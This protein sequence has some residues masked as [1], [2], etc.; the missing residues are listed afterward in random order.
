MEPK[1]N[2]EKR[3]TECEE[4]RRFSVEYRRS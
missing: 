2:A 3:W 4:G 1:P